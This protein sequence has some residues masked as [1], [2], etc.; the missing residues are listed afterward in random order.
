MGMLQ[1]HIDSLSLRPPLLTHLLCWKPLLSCLPKQSHLRVAKPTHAGSQ[2]L[3]L[4]RAL[5]R[6]P[7]AIAAAG[8][9]GWYH[10]PLSQEAST[11]SGLEQSCIDRKHTNNPPLSALGNELTA[12]GIPALH[13]PGDVRISVLAVLTCCR[14]FI[15][16]TLPS[17]HQMAAWEMEVQLQTFPYSKV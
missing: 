5:G 12:Q 13:V 16:G 8:S 9:A 15:H 10:L 11:R 2:W 1:G 6:T 4:S 3:F 17:L 14:C 7:H